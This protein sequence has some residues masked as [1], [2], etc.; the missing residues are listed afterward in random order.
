M[1]DCLF[2]KIASGEIPADVVATSDTA[3]AFRD[4]QPR[5]RVHVLVVPR[6][7]HET[8]AGMAAVDAQGAADLFTLA[9]E[10]AAAEGIADTGYRLISNVGEDG[11]QEV[12]HVHVHLLGGQRVGPMVATRG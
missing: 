4:I 5:T 3:L 8:L 9:G 1:S 6:D 10:V 7:H 11:G 12:G 2:C